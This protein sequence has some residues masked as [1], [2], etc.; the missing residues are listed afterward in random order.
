[1][2]NLNIPIHGPNAGAY[3]KQPEITADLEYGG[4]TRSGDIIYCDVSL[5]INGLS[6]SS[7]FGYNLDVYCQ[8]DNGQP[9]LIFSKGNSP[10][11]WSNG[12]YSGHVTCS[13]INS[14]TSC[15]LKILT[16]SICGCHSGASLETVWNTTLS[17]PSSGFNVNFYSYD[18]TVLLK[19]EQVYAGG[20]A[21]PPNHPARPGYTANGWTGSYKN[22]SSD[23]DCYANYTQNK[24][25]VK[26]NLNGGDSDS[27]FSN[28]TKLGGKSLKLHSKSPKYTITI[29][30]K[31]PG[32]S[33]FG[34]SISYRD[35]KFLGWLCSADGELYQPSDNYT[36]ESNC[37]ML[38]QWEPYSIDLS[39][40]DPGPKKSTLMISWMDK[41]RDATV[42]HEERTHKFLGWFTKATGGTKVELSIIYN[43]ITYYAH[44][45]NA[46]I[47][48]I[49]D[50]N[51]PSKHDWNFI[52]WYL[53]YMY[54]ESKRVTSDTEMSSDTIIY[55][56]WS[57]NIRMYGNGGSLWLPSFPETTET[58]DGQVLKVRPSKTLDILVKQHGVPLQ[59]PDYIMSFIE[60][61]TLGSNNETDDSPQSCDFINWNTKKDGTGTSYSKRY[62][63][64]SNDNAVFYAQWKVKT[65]KVIFRDGW[66]DGKAGIIATFNVPY[67]GSVSTDQIKQ[68]GTPKRDGYS[69]SGW[70]GNYTHVKSNTTIIAV[71]N[72]SPVWIYVS[73]GLGGGYW[74]EY[75]PKES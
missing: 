35:R 2:A 40:E 49:Q 24:Y 28:Q 6:G 42:R 71:W 33:K 67:N 66:H 48:P 64:T 62:T 55:A 44:W 63:Y 72:F 30:L 13:A 4:V 23:T 59:L 29:T 74:K 43:D 57:Y 34:E 61:S 65:L 26:Y 58:Q 39:D 22:V 60:D 3:T 1:M 56:K 73:D 5:N 47:L 18:G 75:E 10:R 15:V 12:A 31:S 9:E 14:G 69:F 21:T 68:L 8:L 11:Q 7:Y 17:A 16:S 25:T 19:T 54:T 36:I 32:G 20:N 37:T 51:K 70:K 50:K 46:K 52:D 38:A 53:D 41:A 45:E 27:S